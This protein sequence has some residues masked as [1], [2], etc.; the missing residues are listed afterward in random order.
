MIEK[1]KKAKSFSKADEL[2]I[3]TDTLNIFTNLFLN[4]K[5]RLV[6]KINYY[7]IFK[8]ILVELRQILFR[9]GRSKKL[10]RFW[11][12]KDRKLLKAYKIK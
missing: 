12:L 10:Y 9:S 4:Y 5:K 7:M 3:T 1:C 6:Q 8:Y 11:S 2:A